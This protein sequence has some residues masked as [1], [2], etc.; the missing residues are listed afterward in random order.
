MRLIFAIA[1]GV[2]AIAA[3]AQTPGPGG[4]GP[5]GM[6]PGGMGPGK[7]QGFAFG[8]SNTSGWSMMSA[9][10]RTAHRDS[11]L[12]A[13]TVDECKALREQHHA[14]MLARAKEKGVTMPSSPRENMCERMK[15]AGRLK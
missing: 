4:M 9:E 3:Q 15:A 7:G 13:K 12:A 6:G 11:M 1:A 14:S 10:E 2:L 5:G 8:P